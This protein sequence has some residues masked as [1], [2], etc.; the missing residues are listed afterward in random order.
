M[1]YISFD[2]QHLVNL[3]FTMNKEILRSNR[4]GAFCNTTII[5]CNT[6]KYHGLLV[7]PQPQ[8]DNYN[9]VL[10][11]SIDET[12]IANKEEFHFGV[13]QYEDGTIMPHGHKYL[14]EFSAEPI[15]KL[16]YRV[17]GTR[18]TK[19]YIF[20][21]NDSRIY[22]RY[23]VEEAQNGTSSLHCRRRADLRDGERIRG[24]LALRY[25]QC[26]GKSREFLL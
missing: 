13:H 23:Y 4:S 15:P 7:V 21:D 17:G 26:R 14:R 11:S 8:L 19:E 16:T 6:R 12:V 22:I 1:A 24:D 3:E 18:I 10:L 9:H 20:A 5:G 2:K 25:C